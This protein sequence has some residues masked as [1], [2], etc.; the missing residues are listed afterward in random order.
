MKRV[1]RHRRRPRRRRRR[2]SSSAP[3]RATTAA[4]YQVRAI[5]DNAFSVIPGEDVKIAGVKVGKIESLDV[6]PDKKAAV[7]LRIDRPG[8][9]DFRTDADCT[10]RPQSLIGEQLRRVHADPAAAGRTPSPPPAAQDRDGGPARAS[11][12]CRSRRPPAGRPRPD[13]QHPAP[14]LPPAPDDH[15]Q[16]ARHRPGGPRRRPA[17]GDHA[18]PTRRSSETDKVLAILADQNKMLA[19]L[20]RDGDT[21]SPRWPA[22]ARRSPT[23]SR[24]P[25]SRPG[26]GRARGALEQNIAK[27]PAFLRE[28]TPTMERLGGLADQVTP[29]LT[30]LGAEAP[31][32]NRFIEELGPVLAGRHPGAPVARRRRRRRRPGADQEQP[33][34]T[35]LG[36][37]A[38]AA[39]P[40]TKNLA[41]LLTSLQGHRRHRAPDGLHL[42]PGG[43]RS[44]AST[45]RPLP[46][47]RPDRQPLLDVRDRSLARLPGELRQRRAARSAPRRRRATTRRATPTPAARRLAAQAR[48]VLRAARRLDLGDDARRT[49]RRRRDGRHERRARRRPPRRAAAPRRA[50]PPQPSQPQAPAARPTRRRRCSTTCSEATADAPRR[51][52]DR[53]QPGAHRGGDDARVIVAVF[54]AYNANTG[55][56]FVPTYELKAE[57]PN[58]ANLVKGND[59]RIGGT[60]VGVVDRH[61]AQHRPGRLGQRAA[62]AQA[63]DHGQAAAGRLDRARSARARRWA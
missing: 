5:F 9:H 14:A 59:V 38:A 61:H 16:R 13:Q 30:D 52:L 25:T 6:T 42:L 32:I 37:L 15:P 55:L 19:D 46:A 1:A 49:R 62:H 2:W 39:K 18:T 60:R 35:D 57:V 22:T 40:L 50:R 48:R 27:L 53:R 28:L 20:A 29:V 11:T 34:I 41:A 58:A 47:R 17:P 51:G 33:I 23:S 44:T 54:L 31:T 45:R 56:P 8:F 12:C 7:V 4:T 24:R 21:S 63:R 43:R 10:I 26:H 3:A 36:Q